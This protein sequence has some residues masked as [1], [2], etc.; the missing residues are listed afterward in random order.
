MAA[1][2]DM[3]VLA[4]RER[5][6]RD[7]SRV[8][9]FVHDK[10]ERGWVMEDQ[11]NDVLQRLDRIEAA[12]VALVEK[13]RVKDWYTTAE[14]GKYL[15]KAEFTVR[16]WARNGRIHAE[17]KGSGRGRF[18]SWVVSHAELLR[19]DRDGLLPIRR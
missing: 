6:F 10:P 3:Q 13:Q 19:I 17:K 8:D 7:F 15:G 9:D 1:P 2:N 18:Q 4:D 16:E 5:S 12:L 11:G 14:A